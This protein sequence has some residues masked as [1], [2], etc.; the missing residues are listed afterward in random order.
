ML[1][2]ASWSKL[3][4]EFLVAKN[5]AEDLRVF[6]NTVLAE[7]WREQGDEIDDAGLAARAER[8]SLDAIPPEVV[9][10]TC[11]VDVQDDRL[12]A[13]VVGWAATRS[14]CPIKPYGAPSKT[15]SLGAISTSF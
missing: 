3:A 1:P 9:M 11:G 15:T 12:E 10:L 6:V 5:D 13:T 8:F 2:N 7:G 14:C 4:A